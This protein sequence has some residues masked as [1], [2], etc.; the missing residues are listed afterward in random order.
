MSQARCMQYSAAGIQQA[1]H[2]R[3]NV[4]SNVYVPN[5]DI[6]DGEMPEI[7]QAP[8]QPRQRSKGPLTVPARSLW[9]VALALIIF[10]GYPIGKGLIQCGSMSR[11]IST[12][13]TE[14]KK[15]ASDNAYLSEQVQAARD[16][17]RICYRAVHEFKMIAQESQEPIYLI[18]EPTRAAANYQT[19]LSNSPFDSAQILG[20]R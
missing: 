7:Y 2:V 4:R 15:L 8:A 3:L 10:F 18:A 12:L 13:Q 1:P 6:H 11:E 14:T 5:A 20:S 16:S 17:V 19:A 9:F